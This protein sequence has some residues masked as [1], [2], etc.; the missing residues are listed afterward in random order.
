MNEGNKKEN[1]DTPS[2]SRLRSQLN[3]AVMLIAKQDQI[4][5]VVFGVFWA[6]NAVLLNTLFNSGNFPKWPIGLIV[7]IVGCVFSLVW[8]TI[9]YRAIAWLSYYELIMKELELTHPPIPLCVAFT[10]HPE[11]VR[12][13]PVRP[14]MLTCPIISAVL[15][16]LFALWFLTQQC[17]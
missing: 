9:E 16:G 15:W 6:A 17:L 12:G 14:I 7:S 11:R 4:V 3:N 8:L 10:G 13:W 5:W 2:E 1:E